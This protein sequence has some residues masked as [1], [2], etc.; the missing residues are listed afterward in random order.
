MQQNKAAEKIASIKK[1][2]YQENFHKEEQHNTTDVHT[3]IMK[4]YNEQKS[5]DSK[6]QDGPFPN[7]KVIDKNSQSSQ[8]EVLIPL[9]RTP[10]A[11][12]IQEA[13]PK[14][15]SNSVELQKSVNS[16]VL[17]DQTVKEN[18]A[19]L[20]IIQSNL[21]NSEN[22]ESKVMNE[23]V[24]I[25][26]PNSD[27]E[28]S[29]QWSPD[30]PFSS[31]FRID[32][33]WKNVLSDEEQMVDQIQKLYEDDLK[34]AKTM[35]ESEQEIHQSEELFYQAKNAIEKS[36]KE[37]EIQM[38][39][40]EME[41]DKLYKA[42]KDAIKARDSLYGKCEN[43]SKGRSKFI[44]QKIDPPNAITKTKFQEII[45]NTVHQNPLP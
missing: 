5:I 45:T 14:L 11:D 37:S 36:L 13:T 35:R 27:S 26:D 15:N 30:T 38:H 43:W 10:K 28:D 32:E 7:G 19:L 29:A 31:N 23:T 40:Y 3:E 8:S 16:Q 6:S 34:L 17:K 22:P 44:Q 39:Q 12:S 33:K 42:R 21:Q 41:Q 4:I 20:S 18:T 9:K 2:I 24:V 25:F 1:L